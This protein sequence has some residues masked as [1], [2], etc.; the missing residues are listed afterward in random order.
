MMNSLIRLSLIPLLIVAVLASGI[1]GV[2]VKHKS[3]KLFVQLQEMERQ[4]DNLEIEWG[5]LRIEQ[6]TWA[7]HGRVENMARADLS[8]IEPPQS[9]IMAIESAGYV[10]KTSRSGGGHEETR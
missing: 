9:T 1:G 8:M 10:P 5:K 2:Y 7:S 3:R 6:S 4:R